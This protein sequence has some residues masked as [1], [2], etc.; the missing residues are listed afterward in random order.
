MIFPYPENFDW[1]SL[2]ILLSRSSL[3]LCTSV[4]SCHTLSPVSKLFDTIH[5]SPPSCHTRAL[6]DYAHW[7][8]NYWTKSP[9]LIKILTKFRIRDHQSSTI[10]LAT[11]TTNGIASP[12]I[13]RTAWLD[14][15]FRVAWIMAQIIDTRS[16]RIRQGYLCRSLAHRKATTLFRFP[17]FTNPIRNIRQQQWVE[18]NDVLRKITSLKVIP[19]VTSISTFTTVSDHAESETETSTTRSHITTVASEGIGGG[20][21]EDV[22]ATDGWIFGGSFCHVGIAYSETAV[23]DK[24]IT[25]WRW[26]TRVAQD[27]WPSSKR[28]KRIKGRLFHA[29]CSIP[30]A[31]EAC[32]FSFLSI[33]GQV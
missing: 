10:S 8:I 4:Q 20:I 22:R 17:T 25:A 14:T 23:C 24:R 16:I 15:S 27:S 21:E 31:G 12:W 5:T 1:S 26:A 29:V 9:N 11:N 19:N 2:S 33:A 6:I 3:F 18:L 32:I 13:S 7:H 28:W 30:K